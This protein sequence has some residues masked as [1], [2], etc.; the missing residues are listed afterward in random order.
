MAMLG[1]KFGFKEYTDPLT[2]R[3]LKEGDPLLDWVND[4]RVLRM[5]SVGQ[6]GLS[7]EAPER[8]PW[9]RGKHS[10]SVAFL[11]M[12][13][14]ES[15]GLSAD[16]Q[17][18]AFV[19]G[20]YHDPHPAGGDGM[21]L[22]LGIS[23][24]GVAHD[25]WFTGASLLRFKKRCRD[26]GWNWKEMEKE[27][28]DMIG[29]KDTSITGKLVHGPD[30]GVADADFIGYTMA[31]L[32][33]G[34]AYQGMN[35]GSRWCE[36]VKEIGDCEVAKDLIALSLGLEL[37][38]FGIESGGKKPRRNYSFSLGDFSPIGRMVWNEK[39]NTWVFTDPEVMHHLV[40]ASTFLHLSLYFHPGVQGPELMLKKG[41]EKLG[42]AGELGKIAMESDDMDLVEALRESGL[43]YWLTP[44]VHWGWSYKKIKPH[45]N[46]RAG[47][48]RF[49][50][51]KFNLRLNTPVL[52][53]GK[54]VPFREARSD[55]A[56]L[57]EA[58]YIRSEREML[59]VDG[60]WS[61]RPEQLI[62]TGDV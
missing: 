18:K 45:E 33:W 41:I 11:G 47:E 61:M 60:N 5:F 31:D 42:I 35:R 9:K 50:V 30:K 19:K 48:Y 23:E 8:N 37:S 36:G 4:W 2:G 13:I 14:A 3:S 43:G 26:I 12:A 1:Q 32:A 7:R 52:M 59:L 16:D 53:N 49:T 58:A 10:L 15:A 39:N 27:I 25:Y 29:R 38:W 40:T 56:F 22:A 54:V 51:P 6:L 44:K 20:L 24:A 57:T 46:E 55:S 34:S 21:K 62:E 17:Q 28:M